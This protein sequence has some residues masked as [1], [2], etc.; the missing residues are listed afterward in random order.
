MLRGLLKFVLS[1]KYHVVDQI[2]ED[3]MRGGHVL[4]T[5]GRR[6]MRGMFLSDKGNGIHLVVEKTLKDISK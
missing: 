3:E 1:I 2:K 5:P 4:D 6:D